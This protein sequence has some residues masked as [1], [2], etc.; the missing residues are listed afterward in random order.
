MALTRNERTAQRCPDSVAVGAQA[1]RRGPDSDGI[2]HPPWQSGVSTVMSM[3][4]SIGD[5]SQVVMRGR[6]RESDQLRRRSGLALPL[7][8][9]VRRV[10]R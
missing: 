10:L 8:A 4:G 2:H 6:L 1:S 9:S 3:C 5:A 7:E